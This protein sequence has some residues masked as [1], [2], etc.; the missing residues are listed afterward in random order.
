MPAS[1]LRG[2]LLWRRFVATQPWGK[3]TRSFV[4]PWQTRQSDRLNAIQAEVHEA[5]RANQTVPERLAGIV[6]ILDY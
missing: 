6:V 5:R 2:A 3:A 4:R 1:G